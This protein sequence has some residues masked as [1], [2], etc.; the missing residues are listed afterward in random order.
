MPTLDNYSFHIPPLW[1]NDWEAAFGEADGVE[2]QLLVWQ[3]RAAD[4]LQG[5]SDRSLT[6]QRLAWINLW[7][8]SLVGLEGARAALGQK[9][10]FLLEMLGRATLESVL[11]LEAILDPFPEHKDEVL[12]RMAGYTA[13]CLWN[14]RAPYD[15]LTEGSTSDDIWDPEPVRRIRDDPNHLAVH[16]A[17][18]GPLEEEF[19][20][21]ELGRQQRTQQNAAWAKLERIKDWLAH[22]EI[23]PWVTKIEELAGK[24]KSRPAGKNG[25]RPAGTNRNRMVSL[26]ALFNQTEQSV[27]KRLGNQG[28]G[29]A[30]LEYQWGSAIIHG[31]TIEQHI[32]IGDTDTAVF[33]KFSDSTGEAERLAKWVGSGCNRILVWLALLKPYVWQISTTRSLHP[34][35]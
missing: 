20:P 31:S 29:F 25:N 17:L 34:T 21:D 30:Y 18:F 10:S 3:K 12:S 33:P 35:P 6:P 16:E 4:L 27:W 9:S 7:T 15:K 8:R 13:W 19:D 2:R 32:I 24:N 1:E 28:L 23:E 22:P 14:D 26:F 11:H 5:I